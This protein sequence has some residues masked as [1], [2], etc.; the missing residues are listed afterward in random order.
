[1][2]TAPAYDRRGAPT[3]VVCLAASYRIPAPGD[4]PIAQR[5]DEQPPPPVA[6]EHV[7]A[8]GASSLAR[9]GQAVYTRPGV[10]VYLRGHARAPAGK[11]VRSML[12]QGAIGDHRFALRVTGDRR[13]RAG[14]V[15]IRATAP[16]PF[17]A[18]P[19]VYERAVGGVDEPRNPVGVGLAAR[20]HDAH[21][22]PLPNLEDP[23][24]P[25]EHPRAR[26]APVGVLPIPTSWSPRREYGGTYDQRWQEERLPYWPEDL[27]LR[28]FHAASPRLQLPSLAGGAPIELE[29]LHHD[30]PLRFVLPTLRPQLKLWG[31]RGARRVPLALDGVELD[32]DA[33]RLTLYYRASIELSRSDVREACVRLRESWE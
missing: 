10:D 11:P 14:I 32:A 15:T 24:S 28:F 3:L 8:P 9:A 4:E 17:V 20:I 33:L 29:G 26:P 6:D 21:D 19:L 31:R 22:A 1:M 13:W 2:A 25:L 7:G 16:A 18:L 5:C 27:D 12:V 23:R 30:G